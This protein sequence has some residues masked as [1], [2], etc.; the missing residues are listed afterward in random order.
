MKQ[1]MHRT[2]L[3]QL[4]EMF[5]TEGYNFVI[6]VSGIF[7]PTTQTGSP[8]SITYNFANIPG[9]TI[10]S[11]YQYTIT[12]QTGIVSGVTSTPPATDYFQVS[13]F[14]FIINNTEY[15]LFITSTGT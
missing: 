5:N 11:N 14:E 7:A 9:I 4:T 1:L 15:L 8:N 3:Q 13:P 10:G 2:N 12:T 6:L